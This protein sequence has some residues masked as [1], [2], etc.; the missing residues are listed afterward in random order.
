M[1]SP[2]AA[3]CLSAINQIMDNSKNGIGTKKINQ[4][5]ENTR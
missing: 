3:Q 4:L 2:I 1:P 5:S